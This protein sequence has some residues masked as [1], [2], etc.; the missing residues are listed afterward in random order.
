[1]REHVLNCMGIVM[2]CLRI[3]EWLRHRRLIPPLGI[4]LLS[5]LAAV[6]PGEAWQTAVTG[7][8]L[9]VNVSASRHAISPYIYGVNYADESFAKEVRLPVRRWGGNATTRYNWKNNMS[10][11]AADWFFENLPE[12]SDSSWNLPDQSAANRFIEQDRRT[13]TRTLMTVPLI[14]WT[15]KDRVKNCGFSRAKYGEQEK[16]DDQWWADCGNG[17]SKDGKRDLTGNDPKDTSAEAGPDFVGEWVRYLVA[18]YGAASQGGVLFYNLDNEPDWWYAT[19]RDVHPDQAGYDEIRDRTCLY[20]P[21]VKAAD[22]SALTLGPASGG[23]WS[24][25]YTAKD[26]VAG[27]KVPPYFWDSNPVDRKAHGDIP[28]VEWYLQQ[29]QAYEKQNGVRILDMLDIHG[30]IAPDAVT[31]DQAGDAATQALRLESTRALWDPTYKLDALKEYPRLIPRMHEWVDRN[32][33]GT[34]IGI[35]EYNW[36]ALKDGLSINGA[37]AQADILGI[38][39]RENLD[40]ATLW[41]PGTGDWN[42]PWSFTYRMFLNYDGAGGSFGDVGVQAA[43]AD[44]GKLALYAAQRSSDSALTMMV[45]NKSAGDLTSTIALSGFVPSGSAKVYRYSA[46]NLASIVAQPDQAL[47]A[48]GFEAT[49]P[50]SSITLLTA[51][52]AAA[53]VSMVFAHIAAGGGFATAITI[54][55]TGGDTANG[56]LILTDKDGR[57]FPVAFTDARGGGAVTGASYPLSIQA[58]GAL[59]LTMTRQGAADVRSGSARVE[60]IGGT[61][62]GVATFQWLDGTKLKSI[63]GVLSGLPLDSAIIPVNNDDASR[64]Y[65]GFGVANPGT[66]DVHLNLTMLREDGLVVD[67]QQP[68]ELNPLAAGK[69]VARFLHEYRAD[70]ATFRGSI[71]LAAQTGEKFAV[72]ALVQDRGQLTAVPVS[73]NKPIWRLVWSDE[74]DGPEGTGVDLTKWVPETGGGGWGNSEIEYYTDR[75][76]NAY[77]QSGSLVI[78]A[79]RETYGNRG[80]TSARLKTQGKFSQ[81]YGRIEARIKLPQGQG[82]WP[83]FWMLGDDFPQVGW[84]ACGEIDIMENIGKEPSTV[85][86]T[87]HGPGYSLAA[88]DY[89]LAGGQKFAD[90]FHIFA[91]EWDADV[92]RWYADGNLFVTHTP[93]DLGGKKWVYDHPF[94]IILNVAVGG[95]WPG[96][97]D[98]TTVFPQKMLVDYVRVYERVP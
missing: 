65:T 43:S 50:A 47:T 75:A 24:A 79:N 44:Q 27:W 15:P 1:M 68:A 19:H 85:H 81:K 60:S 30:Y 37:L 61:L 9:Q 17:K 25:L 14:G 21:A 33:P 86:G 57:T 73:A 97:P 51:Q 45:I 10:N 58:G 16:Y 4:L 56:S 54:S 26:W 18:R 38:F 55:N 13:G 23:W 88:A 6:S 8:A 20:A 74:F 32:Y 82:M 94:F 67:K 96:L 5:G 69:Q 46:G 77:L 34:K 78:Q 28:F 62:T 42:K 98:A 90:D 83:A 36:G 91:I 11:R 95:N 7:P 49:F 29:M 3:G 70:W 93:A 35:T 66:S 71:Q 63:A 48:S 89:K 40:L 92:I 12:G 41:G 53:P 31:G 84:P 22:P 72:V 52:A 2:N 76:A 59:V 87:I 80:F 39:G 64:R